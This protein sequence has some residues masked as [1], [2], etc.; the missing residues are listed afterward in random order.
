MSLNKNERHEDPY[1]EKD[2][3]TPLIEVLAHD[4]PDKYKLPENLTQ[5]QTLAIVKYA[6]LHTA[7]RITPFRKPTEVEALL[8]KQ[9]AERELKSA[10]NDINGAVAGVK[11]A[12]RISTE[13]I[14]AAENHAKQVEELR[15][16]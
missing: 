7:Q 15:S 14:S 16:K 1:Y 5:E 6:V 8:Q 12:M 10:F 13:F 4:F 11:E 9:D 2:G 3:S